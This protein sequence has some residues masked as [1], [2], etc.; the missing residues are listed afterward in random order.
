MCRLEQADLLRES[1]VHQQFE[2]YALHEARTSKALQ[3]ATGSLDLPIQLV[4][5]NQGRAKF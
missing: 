1:F 4:A 2:R 3:L 5:S